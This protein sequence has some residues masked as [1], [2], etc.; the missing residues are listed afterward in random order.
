MALTR[1]IAAACK[2]AV[3][4]IPGRPAMSVATI[5]GIALTVIV[6]LGFL[7]IGKGFEKVLAGSGSPAVAVVLSDGARD[8]MGSS[9]SPAETRVLA[10][11]PFVDAAAGRQGVSEEAYHAVT[12][13]R[14]N[15]EDGGITLRGMTETG[16]ELRP[17]ARLVEGRLF[18]PGSREVVVGRSVQRE[19]PAFE[20]GR[21]IPLAGSRWTVVGV[22]ESPGSVW[23]SELWADLE[24]IQELRGQGAAVQSVRVRLDDPRHLQAFK[25]HVEEDARLNLSVRSEQQFFASQSK[26]MAAV[27]EALGWP[28]GLAMAVGALAGALNTM[29]SSVAARGAE[30]ATLRILGFGGFSTFVS[31]LLE[32]LILACAGAALGTAIALIAID[33]VTST[34]LGANMTRTAF[35]LEVSAPMVVQAWVLALAVGFVGGAIP[36]WQASRQPIL[37]GLAAA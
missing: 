3:M 12:S 32:A 36:A 18:S 20:L 21:E 11:L 35:A 7:S 5:A 8:E 6:L 25:A 17:G 19:F 14:A 16:P 23:D 15:G 28:L 4:G 37:A 22:F 30:I 1:E 2:I 13:V 9:I 27:I 29:Y 10:T 34:T 26:G 24:L 33:N 31:T